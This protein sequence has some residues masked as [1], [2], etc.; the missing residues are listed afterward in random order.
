MDE[1]LSHTDRER[2]RRQLMLHGF[3]AD[4]QQRLGKSTAL[5]AGIGGLGGTAALYLAAA[6]IGRLILAHAGNLTLSNMN[7]QILM[8]HKGIGKS[9]VVQAKKTLQEMNPDVEIEIFDERITDNNVQAL[10]LTSQIT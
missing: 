10:L 6:G 9:R 2:Y 8:K 4:H 5:V 1:H 7:R 3:T